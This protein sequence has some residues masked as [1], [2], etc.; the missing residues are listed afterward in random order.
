MRNLIKYTTL[1]LAA[2]SIATAS[3]A[4]LVNP[5]R[6]AGSAAPVFPIMHG[7]VYDANSKEVIPAAQISSAAAMRSAITNQQGQFAIQ[8]R[9]TQAVLEVSKE[10]YNTANYELFGRS[11]DDTVRIYLQRADITRYPDSYNTADGSAAT[12]NKI[13]TATSVDIKDIGDGYSRSS[14]A[15]VGAIPSL[16]VINKSGM[17]GEGSF[18]NMRG[19]RS[20]IAQ[21]TPTIVIDGVPYRANQNLSDVINGFSL[22]IM[23]PVNVNEVSQFTFLKGADALPY[24]SLGS[25]GVLVINTDEGIANE[26]QVEVRTTQGVGF[27]S[28]KLSLLDAADF[29]S[30]ISNLALTQV[31]HTQMLGMFPFL[32]D[33]ATWTEEQKLRYGYDTDWQSEL[34]RPAFTSDN[35]LKVK[36][37]DAVVRYML[38]AGYQIMDGV[39]EPSGVDKFYTRGNTNISFSDKLKA[40]ASIAFD[41]SDMQL[42]EQGMTRQTNPLLAAYGFAP[43]ST[44]YLYN[45]R[46]RRTDTYTPYDPNMEISN[47]VAMRSETET[48]LR[49]FDILINTGID[50]KFR[51]NLLMDIRFGIT[52][53][54]TKEDMFSGGKTS[55]AVAPIYGGN[56]I[57]YNTVRSGFTETQNYYGKIGFQYNTSFNEKHNLDL[58][59]GWQMMSAKEAASSGSGYN[60]SGDKLRNLGNVTSSSRQVAGYNEVWNWMNGYLTA[61]Y[62][63]DYQ[64]FASATAMVDAASTYGSY[65]NRAFVFP[66]V[67]VGWKIDNA[68]FMRDKNDK[69]ADLMLRAEYSI[70]PNSRYNSRYSTYY[71]VLKKVRDISGLVRAGIPNLKIGPEKVHNFNLGLDFATTG[72]KFVVNLDIYQENTKDMIVEKQIS[73]A[74]GFMTQ[75]RN[76][77]E[78]RTRGMELGASALIFGKGD[79]KWRLGA[80]AGF[81]KTVIRSLGGNG[82]KEEIIDMDNGVT[83]INRI[84]E[85]PYAFYGYVSQGVYRGAAEAEAYGYKTQGGYYFEAGDVIFKD[86]DG[87][88]MITDEDREII[89]DPTP[90]LY[91]SILS[92]MTFKRFTLSMN[93]AFSLGNDIYNGVRRLNESGTDYANQAE[94]MNRR[95][96]SDGQITD[97]PRVT[98]IDRGLNNRFSSRWIE[99]G[100]YLKLKELTLSYNID[101]PVLFFTG[102]RVFLTAQNLL[103][104]TKYSGSDPEFSYSYDM[105]LQGMD[106]AK[107]PVPKFVKLGLVMNF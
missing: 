15:L 21:N 43:V 62:N 39:V 38:T 88:R 20:F 17:N 104:F 75:F 89:G 19:S 82:L 65:G 57:A 47:P 4:Q 95:W 86:R 61:N 14:D 93:W 12:A 96:Q 106:M 55:E 40:T 29:K 77:G 41:Y 105:E 69:I 54:Y 64:L 83:V 5:R 72:H 23:D 99:D 8:L 84:G 102:L 31:N 56:S 13:G 7:V 46:N 26:T 59:L 49:R 74:S 22:D 30:Y 37:G 98:F 70:N 42:Y 94:S 90:D 81:F 2:F 68:P 33:P 66:A 3:Y 24:G 45:E 51:P 44:A 58:N 85:S 79:F 48:S 32:S 107:I 63:Y 50:Y 6:A 28:R 35:M 34:F 25:N 103:T 67:K 92:K 53:N 100:S 60:T 9:T 87:N 16:R 1:V 18:I 10:G 73:S 101:K 91:G 80:N 71:Y 76:D 36:G 97:I 52:Y 78:L 27:I 11:A